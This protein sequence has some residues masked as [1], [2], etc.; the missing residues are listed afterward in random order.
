MKILCYKK[1]ARP[2]YGMSESAKEIRKLEMQL[3]KAQDAFDELS[4]DAYQDVHEVIGQDAYNALN[5][6]NEQLTF[7]YPYI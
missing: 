7:M 5:D 3:A 2:R 6:A 4:D 1:P